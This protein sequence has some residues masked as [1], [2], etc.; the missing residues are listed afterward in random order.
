MQLIIR[1]FE[2]GFYLASITDSDTHPET[3]CQQHGIN[4]QDN[5]KFRSLGTIRDYFSPLAPRD[6]WLIHSCAYDEMIGLVS[7]EK[8]HRQ[9]LYWYQ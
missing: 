2:G 4:Y 8:E 6:I 7:N 9:P 5:M 3:L 1:S